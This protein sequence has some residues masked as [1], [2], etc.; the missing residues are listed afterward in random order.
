MGVW[1]YGP[2]EIGVKYHVNETAWR[3]TL[4]TSPSQREGAGAWLESRRHCHA[5]VETIC[6]ARS[7]V[8]P[9]SISRTSPITLETPASAALSIRGYEPRLGIPSDAGGLAVWR[10]VGS[11]ADNMPRGIATPCA[12]ILTAEEN[13]RIPRAE[14]QNCH[15]HFTRFAP[16]V[17]V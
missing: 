11:A 7:P 3:K 15:P 4:G 8:P 10:V 6:S 1:R 9:S 14:V 2:I 17:L 5:K 12:P 13:L 16:L